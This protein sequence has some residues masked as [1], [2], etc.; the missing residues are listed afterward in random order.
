MRWSLTIYALI[1]LSLFCDAVLASNP[2]ATETLLE[3]RSPETDSPS[4]SSSSSARTLPVHDVGLPSELAWQAWL[5]VASKPDSQSSFESA[6]VPRRISPKSVFVA[7]RLEKNRPCSDGY[8]ADGFGGCETDTIK[9]NPQDHWNFVIE[10]I[11]AMY[12]KGVGFDDSAATSSELKHSALSGPL[13]VNISLGIDDN[14]PPSW[15]EKSEGEKQGFDDFEDSVEISVLQVPPQ[16]AALT[17]DMKPATKTEAALTLYKV[18][19]GTKK[20]EE[21]DTFFRCNS[22]KPVED[23][24]VV[25]PIAELVDDGNQT[26]AEVIDYEI[27]LSLKQ[28][29]NISHGDLKESE[30]SSKNITKTESADSTRLPTVVLLLSPSTLTTAASTSHTKET[31]PDQE[32]SIDKILVKTENLTVKSTEKETAPVTIG[33]PNSPYVILSDKNVRII[34]N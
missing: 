15:S 26:F 22:S 25:V 21:K 20:Q 24:P 29:F 2:T 23:I 31:N 8:K 4:S 17:S 34:D 32:T 13:Q 10:R 14:S 11:N 30:S 6:T 7:P 27:P 9:I 12:P 16:K 28:L 3:P 33:G 1:G 5:V 18:E 19:N